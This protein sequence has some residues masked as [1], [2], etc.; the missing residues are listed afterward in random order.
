VLRKFGLLASGLLIIAWVYWQAREETQMDIPLQATLS[1]CLLVFFTLG[2]TGWIGLIT[3]RAS[4]R[5]RVGPTTG[6]VII[7]GAFSSLLLARA[8]IVAADGELF[9]PWGFAG[10]L[11]FTLM[12]SVSGVKII[13]ELRGRQRRKKTAAQHRDELKHP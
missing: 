5:D 8:G 11:S 4:G 1:G 10:L 12:L 6:I 2:V 7:L 13:W 9:N 3:Y